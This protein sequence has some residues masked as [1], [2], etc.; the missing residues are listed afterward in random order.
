VQCTFLNLNLLKCQ[1][2]CVRVEIVQTRSVPLLIFLGIILPQAGDILG[3]LLEHFRFKMTLGLRRAQLRSEAIGAGLRGM[4]RD[5][6][7]VAVQ[8]PLLCGWWGFDGIMSIRGVGQYPL[9]GLVSH[10]ARHVG[11]SFIEGICGVDNEVSL[12][13]VQALAEVESRDLGFTNVICAYLR[14]KYATNPT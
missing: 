2:I 6:G 5:I 1:G 8:S 7:T 14:D 4:E 11:N 10:A 3:H 12:V 9:L 13:E